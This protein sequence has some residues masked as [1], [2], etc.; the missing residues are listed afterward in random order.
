LERFGIGEYSRVE[1]EDGLQPVN[2]NTAERERRHMLSDK[3]LDDNILVEREASPYEVV[4]EPGQDDL[5]NFQQKI[6][7][8]REPGSTAKQDR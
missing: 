7:V 5:G 8:L 3:L 6:S 1:R 2:S 4:Q